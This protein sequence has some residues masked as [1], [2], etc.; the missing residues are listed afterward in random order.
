MKLDM[1]GRAS[2]AVRSAAFIGCKHVGHLPGVNLATT[3]LDL[4]D[5]II[6]A[7]VY[8]PRRSARPRSTVV[9]VH[10]ST[11]HGH[12]DPRIIELARLMTLFDSTIVV[13]LYEEIAAFHVSPGCST[14]VENTLSA[15]LRR[16]SLLPD[17]GRIAVF[18][19]SFSCIYGLAAAGRPSVADRIGALCLIGGVYTIDP[20]LRAL[21]REDESTFGSD[22]VLFNYLEASIGPAPE[23]KRAFQTALA[24]NSFRR[25]EP[26]LP[27]V[28]ASLSPESRGLFSRLR[29]D[30]DLRRSHGQRMRPALLE[31]EQQAGDL[32]SLRARVTLMHGAGD[33]LVPASETD[34]L[35]ARLAGAG[36]AVHCEISPLIAHMEAIRLRP[37]MA[38]AAARLISSFAR[39]FHEASL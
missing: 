35:R 7:D 6:P 32:A 2:A 11:G 36:V 18:A 29:R 25:E 5:R 26:E 10:G 21:E 38:A 31:L 30:V 20:P 28:L 24:D 22:L 19:T 1:A 34:K 15:M 8:R 33:T 27:A 16:P 12:R 39:F 13:P 23:L 9:L 37:G 17:H 3:T 14:R 4:G